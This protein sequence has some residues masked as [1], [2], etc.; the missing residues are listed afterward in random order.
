MVIWMYH[1]QSV[2]GASPLGRN[3]NHRRNSARR[4]HRKGRESGYRQDAGCEPQVG[5]GQV[6]AARPRPAAENLFF[7]HEAW[8]SR[9]RL[10]PDQ[11]P[12]AQQEQV[13]QP[14]TGGGEGRGSGDRAAE[15]VERSPVEK[16]RASAPQGG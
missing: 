5:G 13:L 8:L 4:T 6:P 12:D 14:V 9:A 3:R 15:P 11:Q 16:E 10:E 2:D 7:E 1:T